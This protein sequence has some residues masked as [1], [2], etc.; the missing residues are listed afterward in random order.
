MFF[1]H[2]CGTLICSRFRMGNYKLQTKNFKLK[3]AYFRTIV[4]PYCSARIYIRMM[5]NSIMGAQLR[6]G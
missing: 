1:L 5:K 3:T 2:S 4:I 6:G